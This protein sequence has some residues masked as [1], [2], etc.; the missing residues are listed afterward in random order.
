MAI[1]ATTIKRLFAKSQNKCAMPRCTSPLTIGDHV[2]AE[3]CHIRARRKKGPRYDASLSAKEKDEFR[4]LILLCPTCHT[5]I[6]KDPVIY[7]GDLLQEIKE[8]HER[9]APLEITPDVSRKALLILTKHE[10]GRGASVSES[11]VTGSRSV[12]A[13]T[14]GIAISVGGHNLGRINVNARRDKTGTG[15]RYPAN[16]IGADANMTNYIEYLCQLYV[17]YMAPTDIDAN[18]L[19]AMLGRQIKSKFRLRKRTRHHLAA[20]R[21]PQLVEYLVHDKLARTPIGKR[22]GKYGTKL[23]RSFDEFRYG[24]M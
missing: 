19:W 23:C 15:N 8:L 17:G 14:G 9:G 1:S 13:S 6:D 12:F 24:V 5:L 3:I 21:F 7:S 11:P 2:L 18:T 16:S 10:D 22:H 4:N 20:E